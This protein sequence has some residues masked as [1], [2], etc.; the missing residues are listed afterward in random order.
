[1]KHILV[2]AS[3]YSEQGPEGSF[4]RDYARMSAGRGYPTGL[5]YVRN[6]PPWNT[7]RIALFEDTDGINIGIMR[8]WH[9]PKIPGLMALWKRRYHFLFREYCTAYGSPDILHA[10]GYL[11]GIAARFLSLRTGI[12]YCI[13][14][15]SSAVAMDRVPVH[16]RKAMRN[17]YRD[18]KR[19]IA[20]SHRL[21]EAMRK[22]TDPAREIT[23]MG[24]VLDV[25]KY[26]LKS[27]RTHNDIIR[28]VSVG[29]LE[30][31]KNY[32]LLLH[33]LHCIRRSH[34]VHLTLIGAGEEQQ[35]L[36]ALASQLNIAGH[37][38]FT[39]NLSRQEYLKAL[40]GADVFASTST[41]ENFGVAIAEALACG[42][43][44]VATRSGGPEEFLNAQTGRLVPSNDPEALAA[45]IIEVFQSREAFPPHEIRT[46]IQSRYDV[47]VIGA[48]ADA[49]YD[50]LEKA[51][52]T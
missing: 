52:T 38:H 19:L 18:A 20:V 3:W 4:I 21:R 31:R 32:A 48:Q 8:A 12:P 6:T 43:P 29:A 36:M 13:T 15:H 45:A 33:A 11:A 44:V 51:L 10:H 30:K 49:L 46:Y 28:L 16:H 41:Y 39:G 9:L 40:A 14:E 37:I 50:S 42:L 24:N 34:S 26:P 35:N 25:E 2:L 22:E 5:L 47:Q 1:M 23:V 7:A 17:A 27:D